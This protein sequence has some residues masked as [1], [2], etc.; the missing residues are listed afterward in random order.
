MALDA[1]LSSC[2]G[3]IDIGD[4]RRAS[5]DGGDGTR[6]GRWLNAQVGG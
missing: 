1:V 6:L 3:Q 5:P 2:I 4:D